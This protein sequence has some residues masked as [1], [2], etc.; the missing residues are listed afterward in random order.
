MCGKPPHADRRTVAV[1]KCDVADR[2]CDALEGV[3]HLLSHFPHSQQRIR[4]LDAFSISLSTVASVANVA[5]LSNLRQSPRRTLPPLSIKRGE[6]DRDRDSREGLKKEEWKVRQET[7]AST[8]SYGHASVEFCLARVV[9]SYRA[10]TSM[11]HW[12]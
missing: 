6:C 4:N 10:I 5:N 12:L 3:S 2:K 7:R 8:Q 1:S 11:T 9:P